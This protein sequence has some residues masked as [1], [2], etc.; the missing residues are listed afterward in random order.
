MDL[1]ELGC[2][3]ILN[4]IINYTLKVSVYCRQPAHRE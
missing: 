1:A 2:S 4:R 3:R